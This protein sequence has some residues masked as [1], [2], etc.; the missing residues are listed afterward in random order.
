[1]LGLLNG[2]DGPFLKLIVNKICRGR[3]HLLG[4]QE[5]R[6]YLCMPPTANGHVHGTD[7][8][9]QGRDIILRCRHNLYWWHVAPHH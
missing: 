7:K 1:M 9:F 4:S 2:I 5:T 3:L 6:A 8:P